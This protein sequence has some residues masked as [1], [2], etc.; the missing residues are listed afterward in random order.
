MLPVDQLVPLPIVWEQQ[1][2]VVGELHTLARRFH[3][4]LARHALILQLRSES[5][6]DRRITGWGAFP[7]A[8]PEC[9][10]CRPNSK[11]ASMA[12]NASP[13]T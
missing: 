1:E 2:V 4:I 11:A 7:R 9:T 10:Q 12:V 13:V 5:C 3:G 8:G 6:T